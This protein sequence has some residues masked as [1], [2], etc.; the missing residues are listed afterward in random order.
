MSRSRWIC[1]AAVAA[2]LA[3]GCGGDDET[4]DTGA[5]PAETTPAETVPTAPPDTTAAEEAEAARAQERAAAKRLGKRREAEAERA[6][7]AIA[8]TL[9]LETVAV[10]AEKGGAL[11]TVALAH[12]DACRSDDESV[13]ALRRGVKTAAPRVKNVK[14]RGEES[15]KQTLERYRE[16]RCKLRT[17]RKP[18]LVLDREGSGDAFLRGPFEMTANPWTL[19]YG[20]TAKRFRLTVVDQSDRTILSVGKPGSGLGQQ[21]VDTPGK[22]SIRITS[23][24]KWTVRMRDGS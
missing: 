19:E 21:L 14:L 18:R 13:A 12:Q 20:S 24:G 2:L 22:F 4:V 17:V 10:A 9:E 15:R 1:G 8:L 6:V 23:S 5:E 3:A 16:K 7:K 11:V